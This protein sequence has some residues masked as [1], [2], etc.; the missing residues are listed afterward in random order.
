MH[1]LAPHISCVVH[2]PLSLEGPSELDQ[3]L[4]AGYNEIY[5]VGSKGI[6]KHHKLRGPN[7]Y[8]RI[9]V[10]K[11]PNFEIPVC[12]P[13]IRFLPDGKIPYSF[14][15]QI[16]SF[17]QQVI[18]LK[19]VALEA[20][21]HILWNAEQGYHIGVPPQQVS[22]A[23]VSYDWSY[24][25]SG[26]SIIVDIH[27]H[28]HMGAFFSGT[29]NNDDRANVSFS[30]VIGKLNEA[31]PMTIWR[32]NYFERKFEAKFD[33]VF[34]PQEVSTPT[35]WMDRIEVR[36][37]AL[38][39]YKGGYQGRGSGA[40]VPPTTGGK[41][42]GGKADHLAAWQYKKGSNTPPPNEE[43]NGN[44]AG[45]QLRH[46]GAPYSSDRG[47][48]SGAA[49]NYGEVTA[50]RVPFEYGGD[51]WNMYGESGLMI[52]E[53]ASRADEVF[54]RA[55]ENPH[56]YDREIVLGKGL[57]GAVAN[58]AR[59]QEPVQT[60]PPAGAELENSA[61]ADHPRY[62]ELMVNHGSMVAESFCL[63]D[64]FMSSLDGKDGLISDILCD[65]FQL[66][67]PPGQAQIFKQL[68]D[69]L[70][71]REQDKLATFGV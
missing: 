18:K 19:G 33:S 64:D 47:V 55:L 22:G 62:E 9:P 38:T 58:V 48:A 69:L 50:D 34:L 26:T 29:D 61:F 68:Y 15:E 17:F 51:F 46:N 45:P 42:Q 41:Q 3:A 71:R 7:R 20:Q 31:T 16:L 44:R 12:E 35:E 2:S 25:P 43:V 59:S 49:N 56:S 21:V 36:T 70:P 39:V 24:I 67:S 37:P 23:S 27:S 52:P 6:V 4:E 8:V 1:I 65:L 32:F 10:D 11:I 30:G 53:D 63:I 66:S 28:N 14:Y 60:E 40:Y 5:V 54:A 13:E 57:G